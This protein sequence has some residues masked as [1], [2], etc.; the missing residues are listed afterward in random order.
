MLRLFLCSTRAGISK[1]STDIYSTAFRMCVHRRSDV[2]ISLSLSRAWEEC[3]RSFEKLATACKFNGS[4][5]R[6][7]KLQGLVYFSQTA[8]HGPFAR[9]EKLS[10]GPCQELKIVLSMREQ[11]YIYDIFIYLKFYERY[12]FDE[13]AVYVAFNLDPSGLRQFQ[14][15]LRIRYYAGHCR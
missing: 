8:N 14:R 3:M 7:A 13:R 9:G 2:T 1:A 5:R 15:I 11:K 4:E 12:L 10:S 6:C